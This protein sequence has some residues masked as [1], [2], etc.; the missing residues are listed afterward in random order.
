ME[1]SA[2]NPS[3]EYKYSP[4]GSGY[5]TSGPDACPVDKKVRTFFIERYSKMCFTLYQRARLHGSSTIKYNGCGGDYDN[6]DND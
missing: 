3:D 5:D 1:T 2:G 4:P 6:N